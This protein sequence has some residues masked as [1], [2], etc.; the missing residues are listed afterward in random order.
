MVRPMACD[1]FAELTKS[2]V[3]I[4][5]GTI[6]YTCEDRQGTIWQVLAPSFRKPRWPFLNNQP[7]S[8]EMHL[9][10]LYDFKSGFEIVK[11]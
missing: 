9:K 5:D 11:P 6:D 1:L 10:I 7:F 3:C 2:N 4:I 8:L